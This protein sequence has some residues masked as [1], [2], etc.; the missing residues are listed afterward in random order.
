M[1]RSWMCMDRRTLAYE[2]G[3]EDFLLFAKSNIPNFQGLLRCPCL[4]CGNCKVCAMNEVREH[5]YFNGIDK[6]YKRWIW[7]GEVSRDD[8][9]VGPSNEP[10]FDMHDEDDRVVEMVRDAEDG[11]VGRHQTFE[12]LLEDAEIPLYDGCTKFTKLSALVRLFNLKAANGWSN[13]SFSDLL[14]LLGE[15]LPENNV[16]PTSMYEAK[17]NLSSLG[18]DYEKI[19][20]CPNDCILYKKEYEDRDDC[21]ICHVSRWKSNKEVSKSKKGIPTKVLWYLPPIP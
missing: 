5:L 21:P 7:H 8:T 13:K 6:S 11:F 9:Y 10:F 16:L 20:A 12:K 4:K 17:K 15:M 14:Q 18:M 2:K 3:I 1:D 19:H